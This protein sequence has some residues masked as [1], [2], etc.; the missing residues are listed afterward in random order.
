MPWIAAT[1]GLRAILDHQQFEFIGQGLDFFHVGGQPKQV[2]RQNRPGFIGYRRPDLGRID[3]QAVRLYIDE[4]G[5]RSDITDGFTGGDKGKGAGDDF[6]T[7]FYPGGEQGQVQ[8]IGTRGA[9]DGMFRA[10]VFA[11][12]WSKACTLGP[13]M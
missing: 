1:E 11:A 5:F 2:Y 4:Y 7:R 6:V 9:A 10:E 3:I 12:S 8:C 13:S